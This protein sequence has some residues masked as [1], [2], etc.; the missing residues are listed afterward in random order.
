MADSG[1]IKSRKGIALDAVPPSD[2]HH[3]DYC[4][5]LDLLSHDAWNKLFSQMV[6]KN[7]DF[8]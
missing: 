3:Q 8:L 1:N 6:V 7:G 5:L 4:I 2:S